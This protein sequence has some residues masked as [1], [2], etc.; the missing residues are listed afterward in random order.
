MVISDHDKG[1]IN[2][3][4]EHDALLWKYVDDTTASEIVSKGDQSNAQAIG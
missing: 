3:L 2:D 4:A 1:S